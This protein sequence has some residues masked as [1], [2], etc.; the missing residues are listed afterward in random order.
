MKKKTIIVILIILAVIAGL[1]FYAQARTGERY[2]IHVQKTNKT[3]YGVPSL[4]KPMFG[5]QKEGDLYGMPLSDE[6]LRDCSKWWGDM[7]KLLKTGR[8][9]VRVGLPPGTDPN[10]VWTGSNIKKLFQTALPA[11]GEGYLY[12]VNEDALI[13]LIT[14]GTPA[15]KAYKKAMLYCDLIIVRINNIK[16]VYI[17]Y[18]GVSNH[19]KEEWED[20]LDEHVDYFE[21]LRDKTLKWSYDYALEEVDPN[22]QFNTGIMASNEAELFEQF[23]ELADVYFA[24]SMYKKPAPK[25]TT[26]PAGPPRKKGALR[27]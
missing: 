19:S 23:D 1:Y 18:E 21:F 20:I 14:E 12:R 7:A 13:E 11:E 5:K 16:D 25:I 17:R 2:L 10:T 26:T 4:P 15:N 27:K 6:E 9:D 3:S 22:D 8:D 24:N